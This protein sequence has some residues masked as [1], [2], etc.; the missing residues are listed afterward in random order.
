M[1]H[2]RTAP[3]SAPSPAATTVLRDLMA[4]AEI[5]SFRALAR[6]A[7]VSDWSVRQLRSDRISSMRLDQL[8]PIAAALNLSLSALLTHFGVVETRSSAAVEGGDH[9]AVTALKAEYQRLQTQL[10]QQEAA[11]RQQFQQEALAGLE[12]WL[13]QWPTVT[14]AVEKNPDLPASRLVPLV[15]PVQNLLESWDVKAIAPVGATVPFDPQVHQLMN[16]EVEPGAPVNV[17][18]TGFRQRGKLLHRAKVSPATE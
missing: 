15:Q 16:G 18:Y 13:L 5:P 10:D 1:S 4:T 17:R 6:A 14:H 7:Q 11:L 9:A 2:D 8:Q 3:K 12:S